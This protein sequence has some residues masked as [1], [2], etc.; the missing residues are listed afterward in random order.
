MRDDGVRPHAPAYLIAAHEDALQRFKNP[1]EILGVVFKELP[2][3]GRA[4]PCF[5]VR[6]S[7]GTED[8]VPV[9]FL[10]DYEIVPY[11]TLA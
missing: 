10:D 11:K 2:G 4:H 8:Y 5:H 1:A 7:T 3:F 6:L 9:R